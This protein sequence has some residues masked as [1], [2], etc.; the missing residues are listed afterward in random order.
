MARSSTAGGR[1]TSGLPGDIADAV[2]EAIAPGRVNQLIDATDLAFHDGG[3]LVRVVEQFESVDPSITQGRA[4]EFLEA[5]KFN[6]AAAEAGN[7]LRAVPTHIEDPGAAADILLQRGDDV[8]AAVQAKSYS[9]AGAGLVALLDSKYR[10]TEGLVPADK[11]D[12]LRGLIDRRLAELPD[13]PERQQLERLDADLQSELAA[14][15]VTS[16]GPHVRRLTMRSRIPGSLRRSTPEQRHSE[17]SARL[18]HKAHWWAAAPVP[19]SQRRPTP[20]TCG[21]GNRASPTQSSTPC[22]RPPPLRFRERPSTLGPRRSSSRRGRPT[23][24]S[25]PV[26]QPHDRSRSPSGPSPAR[27]IDTSVES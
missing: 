20:W 4:F 10:D 8:V 19:C 12:E 6:Q 15:G 21:A 1:I 17:R 27:P 26:R 25:S 11:I 23:S 9:S 7:S 24:S 13:G 3:N 14:D 2:S 16:G 22:A 5:L 18:R